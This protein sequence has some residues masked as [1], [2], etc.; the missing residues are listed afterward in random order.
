MNKRRLAIAATIFTAVAGLAL[1]DATAASAAA[2][3]T[4]WGSKNV[5]V[6]R[7]QAVQS[8]YFNGEDFNGVPRTRCIQ[9]PYG[10]SG[11]NSVGM[12]APDG[13]RLNLITFT[14][15]DCTYGYERSKWFTVPNWD[16]LQNFW[17]DMTY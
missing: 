16:G 17:A 10:Y 3:Y 7:D 14:S 1:C 6:K 11:W 5:M 12:Q 9:L 2:F 8:V 4:D 15:P 13:S